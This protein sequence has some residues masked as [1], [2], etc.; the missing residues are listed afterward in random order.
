V[1]GKR[2]SER[3][4]EVSSEDGPIVLLPFTSIGSHPYS[5]YLKVI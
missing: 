4:W 3:Q 5:T 1:S 2:M